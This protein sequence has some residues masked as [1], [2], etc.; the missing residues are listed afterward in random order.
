[1]ATWTPLGRGKFRITHNGE[2]WYL[3]S[4]RNAKKPWL[5]YTEREDRGRMLV[6]KSQ[7]IGEALQEDAFKQAFAWLD[8]QKYVRNLTS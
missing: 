1:M 3:K 4:T 7:E 6:D 2:V 8:L 5:L